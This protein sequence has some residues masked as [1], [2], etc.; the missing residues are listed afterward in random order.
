M[1]YVDCL[2][3]KKIFPCLTI[4]AFFSRFFGR[5]ILYLTIFTPSRLTGLYIRGKKAIPSEGAPH[6]GPTDTSPPPFCVCCLCQP[7]PTDKDNLCCKEKRLCRSRTTAF[8]NI[9]IDSDNL[10]TVIRSLAERYVF[11]PTYDNR[12]MRHAAYRQCI[13][14]QHGHLG[15][16]IGKSSEVVVLSK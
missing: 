11:T 5:K 13:M 9:C 14:W 4:F 12:A 6:P 3:Y 15:E 7:M 2:V 8:Q 10:S 16:D 1:H